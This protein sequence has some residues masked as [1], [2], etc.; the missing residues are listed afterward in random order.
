MQFGLLLQTTSLGSRLT[1]LILRINYKFGEMS[2][3]DTRQAWGIVT[4]AVDAVTESHSDEKKI[5]TNVPSISS[6][7][8]PISDATSVKQSLIPIQLKHLFD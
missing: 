1:Y 5:S 8:R 6:I 2:G 4:S 7:I 3:G